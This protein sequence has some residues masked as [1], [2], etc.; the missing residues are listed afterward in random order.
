[1]SEQKSLVNELAVEFAKS[2]LSG[3]K[4]EQ[5]VLGSLDFEV[6]DKDMFYINLVLWE[7]WMFF[8]ALGKVN[9]P[10]GEELLNKSLIQIG[11][12]LGKITMERFNYLAQQLYPIFSQA[13]SGS[14]ELEL[15]DILGQMLFGEEVVIEG[16]HDYVEKLT[17]TT[18]DSHR[19]TIQNIFP[20]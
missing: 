12:S 15:S 1:M 2:V 4:H 16:F 14:H 11:S 9:P 5:E 19:K 13:Y 8:T 20:A 17:K 3:A 6:P 18:I 7:S 10:Q